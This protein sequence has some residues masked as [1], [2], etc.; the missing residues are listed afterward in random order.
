MILPLLLPHRR[1][2]R[3]VAPRAALL[4]PLL[5]V[6]PIAAT[7]LWATPR[8]ARAQ[9]T[10]AATAKQVRRTDLGVA[11]VLPA[12]FAEVPKKKA[13]AGVS[14]T[15]TGPRDGEYTTTIALVMQKPAPPGALPP[16]Y[17]DSMVRGI[18]KTQP[19]FHP[20]KRGDFRVRGERAVYV[21]GTLTVQEK[22]V[23]LYSV[24]VVRQRRL[25]VFNFYCANAT[26]SQRFPAFQE[27]LVS[28]RWL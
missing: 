8:E 6:V 28:L 15:A 26:F 2:R 11:F 12:G 27:M 3:G 9:Q 10:A 7:A 14:W 20:D 25:Y 18:Q 13:P 19:D 5:P 22:M 4:L 1:S 23:R 24:S 17:L 16:S 21:T